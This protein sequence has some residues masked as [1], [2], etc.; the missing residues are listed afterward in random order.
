MLPRKPTDC[1]CLYPHV[2]YVDITGHRSDCP[3]FHRIRK[4]GPFSA[5]RK[6]LPFSSSSLR[7]SACRSADPSPPRVL[8]PMAV[9][10][11]DPL[12]V[13][14]DALP[15]DVIVH[16]CTIEEFAA[17]PLAQALEVAAG[18]LPIA[19][20]TYGAVEAPAGYV[21]KPSLVII[22]FDEFVRICNRVTA[23]QGPSPSPSPLP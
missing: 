9:S 6:W 1:T 17:N 3:A 19:V 2:T 11:S 18:G 21:C 12:Q 7:S 14:A 10:F 13:L 4:A 23:E 8:I 20:Y 15:K 16:A 22:S 5:M